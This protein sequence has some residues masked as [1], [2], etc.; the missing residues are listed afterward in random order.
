MGHSRA[1][2]AQSRERI[3]TAAARQIREGGLASVSIAD[4]MRQASLT[5]GGFYG[6]FP[7]RSDL[8]AAALERALA[9]GEAACAAATDASEPRPLKAILN[10]YLSPAHR[11]NAGGGCAAPALASDVGR[12][13]PEV[14]A[15][16]ARR[17]ETYFARMSEAFEDDPDADDHAVAAWCTMV[18]AIV[19]ARVFRGDAR[20]DAILRQARKAI[21]DLQDRGDRRFSSTA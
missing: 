1:D 16:M 7:S 11:D 6:H 9:E 20:S 2:K 18:G 15:I 10:S 13:E 3:I 8:I 17:L 4:L 5:H 14:R 21:L 12:A 19:L